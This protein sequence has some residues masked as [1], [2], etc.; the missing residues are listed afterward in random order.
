MFSF[1]ETFKHKIMKKLF[2][3]FAILFA[4][5]TVLV[6]CGDDDKKDGS[7]DSTPNATPAAKKDG[8][9]T[10]GGSTDGGSTDGGSTDGGSTDG[11]SSSSKST[12]DCMKLVAANPSAEEAPAGCEWMNDT[13]EEE[14]NKLM[15]Q[16]MKDCPE[17][18]KAL[19][20]GGSDDMDMDMGGDVEVPTDPEV[21]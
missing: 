1:I 4:A 6:S 11:G 18:M 10:N 8:G 16:A 5:S 20:M 15:E 2:L 14:T 3:S 13:S 9:S 19:G 17:T 21:E 12:C 7:S